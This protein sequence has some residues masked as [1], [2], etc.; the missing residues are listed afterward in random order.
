MT[1]PT[2]TEKALWQL[3]GSHGQERD[4]DTAVVLLEERAKDNDHEAMWIL[5][6]CCEYGMGTEKNVKRAEQLYKRAAQLKNTK[7]KMMQNQLSNRRGRGRTK[8]DLNGEHKLQAQK[9]KKMERTNKQNH[10]K[11][12]KWF[13]RKKHA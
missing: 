9:Q 10:D 5:G 13:A 3:E 2:N 8:M 7:A 4:P 11:Q 1:E 6:V 12:E